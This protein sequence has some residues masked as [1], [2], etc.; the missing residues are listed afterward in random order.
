MNE[1]KL[2]K[3]KALIRKQKEIIEAQREFVTM[4]WDYAKELCPIQI[5][6]VVTADDVNKSE[7]KVLSIVIDYIAEN[8]IVFSCSGSMRKKNGE[9]GNRILS[10]RVVLEV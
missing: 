3:A 9:F 4:K 6:D 8:E 1:A 10:K 2:E 7:I 5:N